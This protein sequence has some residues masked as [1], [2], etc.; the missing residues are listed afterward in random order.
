[1]RPGLTPGY[2]LWEYDAG[3]LRIGD[4]IEDI[5]D[6]TLAL[7]Q[8]GEVYIETVEWL[9]TVQDGDDEVVEYWDEA[10]A[11]ASFEDWIEVYDGLR[12]PYRIRLAR[13][14]RL[15]R[16]V[17]RYEYYGPTMRLGEVGIM[18]L[19]LVDYHDNYTKL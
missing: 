12:K 8:D 19:D 13:V 5:P 18:A 15:Y 7:V 2:L 3:R 4:G 9:V 10:N 11:K 17:D 6:M 16:A 14:E 1:M